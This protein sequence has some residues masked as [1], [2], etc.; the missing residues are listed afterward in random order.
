MDRA[1]A[2]L[3]D[4]VAADQDALLLLEDRQQLDVGPGFD[5]DHRG[6]AGRGRGCTQGE[7][8]RENGAEGCEPT[9]PRVGWIAEKHEPFSYTTGPR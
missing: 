6:G 5:G 3:I 9:A 4:E 2:G 1:L 7:A 8:E